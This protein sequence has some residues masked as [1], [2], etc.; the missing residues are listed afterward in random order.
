MNGRSVQQDLELQWSELHAYCAFLASTLEGSCRRIDQ[1]GEEAKAE[2]QRKALL[3]ERIRLLERRCEQR[4]VIALERQ[5]ASLQAELAATGALRGERDDAR[6]ALQLASETCDRERTARLASDSAK[7]AMERSLAEAIADSERSFAERDAI[8]QRLEACEAALSSLT[9]EARASRSAMA[10]A[11]DERRDAEAT[12]HMRLQTM[13]EK[14]VAAAAAHEKALQAAEARHA[15]TRDDLAH[16]NERLAVASAARADAEA[17]A[18]EA[19]AA[20]DS[21]LR[22]CKQYDDLAKRSVAGKTRRT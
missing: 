12:L 6:Q 5:V 10:K 3:F 20:R 7:V 11:S 8:A 2:E 1:L 21:A 18:V 17:K 16:L 9:E 14:S 15:K 4:N 22:A 13:E 19:Q